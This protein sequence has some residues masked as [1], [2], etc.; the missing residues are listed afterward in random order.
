MNEKVKSIMAS[1]FRTD[2]ENI[3]EDLK[4]KD[5]NFW[6]SLRHLNLVVELEEQFEISFEPEEIAEMTTFQNVIYY[7]NQK[8]IQK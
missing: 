8:L 6:D 1:V 5:V 7:I 2:I 3:T 4:Q